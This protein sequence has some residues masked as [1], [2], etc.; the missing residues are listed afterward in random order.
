MTTTMLE[1]TKQTNYET[2]LSRVRKALAEGRARAKTA[3]E[4]EEV[5]TWWEAA[6]IVNE[7]LRV[8]E[9]RAV[10]GKKTVTHLAGDLDVTEVY[11][12]DI[13][14]FQ[15]A[16]PI[17]NSSLELTLSHYRFLS[18]I[19]N[20]KE[21]SLLFREALRK[22]WSVPQLLEEI[23]SRKLLAAPPLTLEKGDTHPGLPPLKP[24]RGR[25]FTYRIVKPRDLHQHP[26]VYSV[27]LGFRNRHDLLLTG[28]RNPKEGDLIEAVRMEENPRGDRYRFKRL[29]A[30]RGR[31]FELLYTYKATVKNVIDDDTLWADVDLGFRFWT[32][33]KLRLRGIDAAEI[34]KGKPA[35]D[36]VKRTLRRVSFVVIKLSGRD[37][38]G[39]YLTDLFYLEG[40]EEREK[41]L[42]DGKFLNQELLD[43]GLARR[44]NA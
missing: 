32:E 25:F 1:R 35:S 26:D 29:D 20:S 16:F 9:G 28:I 31:A 11:L 23:R 27:D 40:T 38:Y 21:R 36:F 18:K 14:R 22:K 7:H 37:K 4:R 24:R 33:W 43:L 5:R 3:L 8:H 6:R 39:R 10:Y 17:L 41:V 15:R 2:L 13:L 30:T 34:G 19:E 44:M 42:R 12:Y